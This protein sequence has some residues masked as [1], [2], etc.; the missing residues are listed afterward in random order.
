MR[1]RLRRS[2]AAAVL[3]AL[4]ASCRRETP[5]PLVRACFGREEDAI[6]RLRHS[7][8][9]APNQQT[10]VQ[11]LTVLEGGASSERPPS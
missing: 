3:A 1:E 9:I 4:V 11:S 2:A 8:A 7:L 5:A 10:V 6:V